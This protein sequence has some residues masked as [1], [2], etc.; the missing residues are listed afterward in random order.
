VSSLLLFIIALVAP[1]CVHLAPPRQRPVALVAVAAVLLL[2]AIFAENPLGKW[3][4]WV[5]LAA[6]ILSILAFNALAAGG[7]RSRGE[8]R[9]R[10]STPLDEGSEPTGEL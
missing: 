5:G 9:S 3:Q 6:G 1:W 2:F 10:R 8:R 7:H 4:L